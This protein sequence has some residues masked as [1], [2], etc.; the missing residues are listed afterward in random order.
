MF[1]KKFITDNF[2]KLDLLNLQKISA[3]QQMHKI[4]LFLFFCTSAWTQKIHHQVVSS[5]G[6]TQKLTNG[7][8]VSQSI[9]Q[10]NAVIGNFK[11]P[12]ISIG[13]GYIQSY[14]KAKF[15]SPT[16]AV[17]SVVT[18]P[19]P[20]VD[21]VNFRF[22]SNVGTTAT[23]SLFDNRGRLVYIEKQAISQELASLSLAV[24][25]EGV[26]FVKIETKDHDFSTKIIISK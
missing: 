4:I 24:L 22:S 17:V 23:I 13:Q 14:G 12:S 10:A 16:K 7:M 6:V 25:A 2:A 11:N 19:N 21:H 18:Y 3:Q 26:Y 1:F 5:Q 15:T 9:G 20:V 8:I